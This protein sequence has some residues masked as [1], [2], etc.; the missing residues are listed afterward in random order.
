VY[1]KGNNVGAPLLFSL[2][3]RGA[4]NTV[5]ADVDFDTDQVPKSRGRDYRPGEGSAV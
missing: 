2:G 4:G 5:E 1:V 3:R